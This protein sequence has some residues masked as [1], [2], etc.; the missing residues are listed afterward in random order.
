M[1]SSR[2]RTSTAARGA[3]AASVALALVA[4]S[5][6]TTTSADAAA[7]T[8]TA[9]ADGQTA[10]RQAAATAAP[11]AATAPKVDV[12]R[13][14]LG[15]GADLGE[16]V[17]SYGLTAASAPTAGAQEVGEQGG[18]AFWRTA[19]AA[20]AK[21]LTLDVADGY[22]SRLTSK[23]GYLVVD[24]LAG[25]APSVST[26][27]ADGAA[28]VLP[29]ST[30]DDADGDG[31]TTTVVPLPQGSLHAGS[32]GAAELTLTPTGDGELTV[33]SVRV[34]EQTA[35]VDLG[36]TVASDG[37]S[38]RAG[39]NESGLVTGTD[40]GHTYWQTG[41]AAGTNFV[42]ANVDDARLYDTTD[43]VL[44]DVGYQASGGSL[45]LEYDSPGETIP[46]K[47]KDSASHDLGTGGAWTDHVWLLDDAI[48]TN[49]S[50]GSD[51]RVSAEQSSVDVR[52]DGVA[53][54]AVPLKLDPTVALRRLI[55]K[56]DVAHFAA[57][58]GTRDGQ[59]PAGAKATLQA[60]ID[61]AQA[62]VDDPD[63]TGA[64]I[65]TAIDTLVASLESFLA[66]QRTTDL[67]RGAIATASSTGGGTPAALTDGDGGTAWT[68]KPGGSAW[69]QVDLGTVRT[70][71][72]ITLQWTGDYANAYRVEVSTDGAHY[73]EVARAG[74]LGGGAL[75]TRF[76]PVD[77]RY[78]RA[79]FDKLAVQR[80]AFGLSAFEVRQ[81]PTVDLASKVVKTRF[82]TE[83]VV[84]AD[85]DASDYGVDPTG[86]ADSTAGI[87]AALDTCHDA[88]G[89][90]VWL[91]AG[92]Y[93]VTDTIEVGAYCTLRGD[94]QDP[95]VEGPNLRGDYG[96]VV[97]ADLPSGE[98]GPSLFL[99]GGSAGVVGLTTYY[100]GQDAAH[101]VPYG[102]TFELPGLAWQ[103]NQNYMMSSV[104]HV[105]MLNSY[106]GIGI[107]TRRNDQGGGPGAQG[108]ELAN[109][110]DVSGTVLSQGAAGF[111]GADVGVW[112]DVRF[113]NA[114]WAAA[115]KAFHA[116]KRS[117]LDAWTRAH[118][119]GFVLGDL[120][121]DQFVGLH[122]AD[123][124]VG[125]DVVKGPRATFTGAFV[126]A[127]ILR[128]G[129]A[130]KVEKSDD[131]WGLS[132]A[133]G[134]LEGS[135]A[136]VANTSDGYV[137]LTGVTTRG[138]LS[139][140]V[141]VLDSATTI[142]AAPAEAVTAKPRARLFDVTKAPYSVPRTP[143]QLG[144]T[145][146]TAAIQRALDDAGRAG[147]GVVYLPAGWY[148]VTGHLTV[149]ARVE[150]RGASS[151]PQ[152]DSLIESA[153][154]VL[155]ASEGRDAAD[156]DDAT[157][158][159]TLAGK[160]AGVRGL[161]VFYPG[162]NPASSDGA[163]P[164]PFTVRGTAPQVYV[165]NVGLENSWNAIDM[166]AKADRFVVRRVVGLFLND[167]VRAGANKGGTVQGVLSNGNVATRMAYGV[168]GW[169][170]ADN[171]FA[172]VIDGVSRK[173]EVLVA[174]HGSRNLTVQDSFAYGAHDGIV[175]RDG[176]S[177]T[178]FNIGTDNLGD[179]GYTA[180]AD[181]TSRITAV[182]LMRYNGTTSRGP[183]TIVNPMA[184]TMAQVSFTAT[185]SP[186]RGG[187]VQVVGNE[188]EPG[189]YEKGST[190]RLVAEP[191][192]AYRF[193]G[194][195]DGSGQVVS[196]AKTLDL[197]LDADRSLTAEFSR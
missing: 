47:F 176:A 88:G 79:S 38:V 11:S 7:P 36:P 86:K 191:S 2:R 71:S 84:V 120:E 96:T 15:V 105:T 127:D 70:V 188:T 27:E 197:V 183:V 80:A 60:A 169:V 193:T 55:D 41:R 111:N 97:V 147:G 90:T 126:D 112:E 6:A 101:P 49:R 26:T 19:Q 148:T 69:A 75:E 16:K 53:V 152:R 149:P 93:R 39:D 103:G 68:S 48:L 98:D 178:A 162:N 29:G 46:E 151:V 133:G 83:D 22:V 76:S 124:A 171:L 175:A 131:R 150:L 139:G 78:V 14:P 25:T 91:P 82:P 61:A 184:I 102:Y 56:A 144:S 128:T 31:W 44:V 122:A 32:D 72:A 95:D 54:T 92:R 67:A 116:P 119:T 110:R 185:A 8:T 108:H 17:T 94:R 135:D 137:K 177:V 121:W 24:H 51:F 166:T 73:T 115:G 45:F 65:D 20:G 52:M 132:F 117:V 43:R 123:Y 165:V 114:Y 30:E 179:G 59:Y 104:E 118:G 141:H 163:V 42:Y 192:G 156:A 154:T 28:V 85:V 160:R 194:W 3:A 64:E 66:S 182:N 37:I 146:A 58:E 190:V 107:S 170:E 12:D 74:A 189:R 99:V 62:V 33:A 187:T 89:G 155:M 164:Y 87:Q 174:A 130:V 173:H 18:R 195:R 138:A 180:D 81:V 100:P 168:P 5:V 125:I 172:Q 113:D 196:T 109:V 50:N 4:A 9:T 23:P 34:V 145:D 134:T 142:P 143:S 153:G 157:A 161:R 63:A 129:T 140:T 186:V 10:A 40:A 35:R 106:R 21:A 167:G 159:V 57:R 136:A 181:D 1:E 158:L 13:Y 77:A